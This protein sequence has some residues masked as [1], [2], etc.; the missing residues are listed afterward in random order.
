MSEGPVSI[1]SPRAFP[2]CRFD[3]LPLRAARGFDPRATG[4]DTIFVLRRDDAVR[5]F[6]NRCPHQ[7][8]ALEYRKDRFLTADGKH[9]MCHAHGALFDPDTGR[10]TYGACL[11]Q[12]LDAVS[13]WLQDGWV[14]V[15]LDV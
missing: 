4:A 12:T 3:E 1:D 15:R 8:V 2:L 9:I 5:A 14:W 6:V 11:G 13:C 7:D 10:C